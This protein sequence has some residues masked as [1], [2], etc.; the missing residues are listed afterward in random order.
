MKIAVIS[1]P[2][3][4]LEALTAVLNDIKAKGI[5]DIYCLGDIVGYGPNPNECVDLIAQNCKGAVAGNHDWVIIEKSD[6]ESF[7]PAAVLAALW[8]QKVLTPRSV[9]FLKN[10]ELTIQKNNYLFVHG[11]PSKPQMFKYIESKYGAFVEFAHFEED[12]CF[13]GHTHKPA[14]YKEKEATKANHKKKLIVNVGSVGQPRDDNP[15]AC[16]TIV[17][18]GMI[19]FVRVAYPI[20]ETQRKMTEAKLPI[21]LINRLASGI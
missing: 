11:T 1:D 20:A 7:N 9:D 10:L 2:H 12:I 13:I 14:I 5:T 3:G 15:N 19:E 16:Y 18:N 8:T 4:N 6:G 21:T 17:N